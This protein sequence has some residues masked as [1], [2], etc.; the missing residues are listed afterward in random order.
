[1]YVEESHKEK[2]QVFVRKAA[3]TGSITKTMRMTKTTRGTETLLSRCRGFWDSTVNCLKNQIIW[4]KFNWY[5]WQRSLTNW[6]QMNGKHMKVQ[7]RV[8][9]HQNLPSERGSV[10][11]MSSLWAPTNCGQATVDCDSRLVQILLAMSFHVRF[12]LMIGHLRKG[13][14][15]DYGN[16]P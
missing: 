3:F 8:I 11:F 16:S 9:L 7:W 6:G 4:F 5:K 10:E 14:Q 15:P 12:M 2:V 1:M 13:L